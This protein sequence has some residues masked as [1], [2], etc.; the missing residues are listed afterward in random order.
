M[1][2]GS[3]DFENGYIECTRCNGDGVGCGLA[4]IP[5]LMEKCSTMQSLKAGSAIGCVEDR[6]SIQ[7][8]ELSYGWE[9]VKGSG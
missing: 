8:P 6:D 9:P 2:E 1:A 5:E 3:L 4:Q 7:A